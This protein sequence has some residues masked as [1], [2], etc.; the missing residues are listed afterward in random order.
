M[1]A[2]GITFLFFAPLAYVDVTSSWRF[3]SK[4][5]RMATAAAGMYV[6]LFAAAIALILWSNTLPGLRH[7]LALNVAVMASFS[8]LL[9]NGNPLIRFDGYFILSDLLEIP[10][11]YPNS[12]QYL[13]DVIQKRVG[14]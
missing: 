10:N 9:F 5:H 2:A 1:P 7:Y 12:Q 11:L 6:E 13:V 3:R 4:W 14:P 8:T